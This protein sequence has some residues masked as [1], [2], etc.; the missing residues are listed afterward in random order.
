M[1]T[2]RKSHSLHDYVQG[3]VETRNNQ[4]DLTCKNMFLHLLKLLQILFEIIQINTL[5]NDV[6]EWFVTRQ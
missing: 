2:L 5:R 3:N 4:K 1:N 6:F